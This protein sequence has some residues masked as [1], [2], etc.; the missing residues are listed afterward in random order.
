MIIIITL[1]SSYSHAHNPFFPPFYQRPDHITIGIQREPHK[2]PEKSGCC[3]EQMQLSFS[4]NLLLHF[5]CI[6]ILLTHSQIPQT[7]SFPILYCTAYKTASSTLPLLEHSSWIFFAF[8]IL[9][10]SWHTCY[11][12]AYIHCNIFFLW[13]KLFHIRSRSK[14]NICLNCNHVYLLCV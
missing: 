5:V 11:A 1:V 14:K 8:A 2:K 10:E 4:T 12:Y 6:F 3:V 7:S 13:E 9:Q